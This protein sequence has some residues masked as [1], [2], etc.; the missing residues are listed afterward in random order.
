MPLGERFCRLALAGD[1]KVNSSF[2]PLRRLDFSIA[3]INEFARFV[4]SPGGMRINALGRTSRMFRLG[5]G[6]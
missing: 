6:E 2:G 5:A 4:R 3:G 1:L